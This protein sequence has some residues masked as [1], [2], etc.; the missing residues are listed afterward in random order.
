MNT[1][2]KTIHHL[3]LWQLM[4]KSNMNMWLIIVT[5]VE[6]CLGKMTQSGD[7]GIFLS[8]KIS[9]DQLFQTALISRHFCSHSGLHILRIVIKFQKFSWNQQKEKS[10]Q[11]SSMI[12]P[13]KQL[14]ASIEH[15]EVLYNIK[16]ITRTHLYQWSYTKVEKL[17]IFPSNQ[18]FYWRSW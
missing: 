15:A 14:C 11:Y 12:F 9:R 5:D 1:V 2:E 7:Y 3:L 10:L 13:W 6:K 18:R 4:W 17:T 16:K 8:T